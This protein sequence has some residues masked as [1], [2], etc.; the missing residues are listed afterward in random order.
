MS[1]FVKADIEAIESFETIS[2]EAIQEFADIQ[3]KFRDINSDL[4]N[5]WEGDGADAYK[6]ETDHILE[7]I[8]GIKDVLDSI[9][10]SVIKDIKDNYNKLDEDLAEFN[11]NP[12]SEGGGGGGQASGATGNGALGA[13]AAVV[14][15]R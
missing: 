14:G 7:N 2:A 12:P 10:S 13:A 11:R 3:Q 15:A 5:T 4:L 9:N 6:K 8:G 1:A